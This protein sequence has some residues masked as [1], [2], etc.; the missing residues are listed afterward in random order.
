MQ[1]MDK[2][3]AARSRSGIVTT[4][5]HLASEAG[6]KVLRRGGTAIEAVVAAGAALT[7][8]YPHFCG[9]GG[10][11]LWIVAD[12]TGRRQ[13]IMGIGQ[14]AATLPELDAIPA[15]GPLSA[16][17]TAAVVDSWGQALAFSQENWNGTEKLSTLLEYAIGLAAEGFPVSQSLQHWHAFRRGEIESWPGVSTAFVTEGLQRQPQ[18]ADALERIARHGHREFYEGEL[19][20][21]IAKA[22]EQAGSPIRKGDLQKT[23]ATMED[24]VSISYRGI[25]LLAPPPPSQGIST[26]AIMGILQHFPMHEVDPS[27]ADFYHLCVEAVK[28]A[29]LD[30]GKIADPN[31]V[32]QRCADLLERGN[33]ANKAAA[34]DAVSAMSWPHRFKTGDTVYLAAVDSE[35]RS[36]SVLQSTYY[37]WG[38]GVLL[39]DTGILWQNRGAAFSTD[40]S[41][42]NVLAPGKRPF[43]TL[44]PGLALKN[45]LPHLL[46]GTQGA[47]GQPQTLTVL[48]SRLIDH[49]LDPLS[50]LSAPRFL[51][52]RT[53]SDTRDNLKVEEAAG[54]TVL[55]ELAQ[56]GHEV[57]PI[58]AFSPLSGQAGI[59]RLNDDG[60]MDGAHD[61][62]SDG[63][64]I[65][66]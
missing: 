41:S 29:F 65:G 28:Q 46:Y 38:S 8:L 52:G 15:R 27:S 22:L 57:I 1:Q 39:P 18:M 66:I 55:A 35:G 20:D 48:L 26:L 44:N 24:P 59:I 16:L 9:L 62:R 19:A 11:A 34:I 6:A 30:R 32:A 58:P 50:A 7:V 40:P 13:A 4:P 61:P 45:G 31:F 60:W 5:H 42:P 54:Q 3:A 10:D 64:A 2:T 47:D 53:F 12:R 63:C 25:E 17:T 51:L 33:L 43:Y 23:A 56:R 36:A 14:A 21:R 49:G 37:D